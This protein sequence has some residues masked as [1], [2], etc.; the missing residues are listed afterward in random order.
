MGNEAAAQQVA[1]LAEGK[2]YLAAAG[3]KPELI[4]SHFAQ[5]MLDRQEQNRQ[6][7]DWKQSGMSWNFGNR[8]P[9]LPAPDHSARPIRFACLARAK[10]GSGELAYALQTDVVGGLF[11]WERKTGYER[12][13]FHRAQFSARDLTSPATR[14]T[15]RSPWP[16]AP[17]TARSTSP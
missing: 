5:E 16:S 17:R 7:N 13:L 4:E 15:A 11:Y 2:L 8:M 1:F 10:E 3:R 6:R 12:R 14:L 9:G